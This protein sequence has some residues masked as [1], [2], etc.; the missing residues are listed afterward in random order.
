MKKT[1]NKVRAMSESSPKWKRPSDV[2]KIHRKRKRNSQN[3][4]FSEENQSISPG[5]LNDSTN[6]FLN[7]NTTRKNPFSS[8]G[9][10]DALYKRKKVESEEKL[11]SF[12]ENT[13]AFFAILEKANKVS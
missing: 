10:L 1:L 7:C 13:Q 8:D 5:A 12:N 9:N 6:I 3:R 2:M 11:P 4:S